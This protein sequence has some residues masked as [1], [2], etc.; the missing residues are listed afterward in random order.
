[1]CAM[2]TAKPWKKCEHLALHVISKSVTLLQAMGHLL[3]EGSQYII[4]L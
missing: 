1:M 3:I 4:Y 2:D